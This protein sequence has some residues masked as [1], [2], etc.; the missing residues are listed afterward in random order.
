MMVTISPHYKGIHPMYGTMRDFQNF[1]RE[2]HRRRI[3]VITELVIN[4]T[5]DQHPWFQVARKPRQDQPAGTG[6]SG[7][8]N[9]QKYKDARII[10][11]D[12]ERSNWEWDPVAKAY[13]WHRFFHHQPDLN[14]DNPAV[15]REIIKVLHFWLDQGVDGLR[16]DAVPYLVEREGTLVKTCRKPTPYSRRSAGSWTY[17]MKTV[18]CWRKQTSGLP[19]CAPISATAMNAT[20]LST[21]LSCLEY[22]W[23]CD[24]KIAILSPTSCARHLQ[25]PE[26]CQWALF[27][28]NHDELTL[29]MV[30]D[31]ERDYM[32]HS[33]AADP[34][35]RHN[36]G[37]RRRL[38]PLMDNSRR[39]MELLCSLLFSFRG[40]P[41]IYYGDEIGMGDN[42]YLGDRN[43][44]R[45][46]MQWSADRNAGFSRAD[47]AQLY[48]PPIM[49]TIYG[50]Q[51]IN[52]EAQQR[53]PSSL[54]NWMKHLI[55][56]RNS[57]HVFGRG[58]TEFLNPANR[59]VLVHIR[60]H[61]EDIVL[62][63][64][65]LSRFVQPA[66]LDLSAYAGLTPVEMM[67]RIEFPRISEAPY[68]LSLG[69]H[70]FYWFQLQRIPETISLRVFSPPSE[71]PQ[72]VPLLEIAER[73]DS[74]MART[75]ATDHALEIAQPFLKRQRWFAGKSKEIGSATIE[76]RIFLITSRVLAFIDL[77]RVQYKG[78][79]EEMYALPLA[80]VPPNTRVDN[81]HL[82]ARVRTADG[83]GLLIDAMADDVIC[84]SLL[85]A[86]G[87]KLQL[88]TKKGTFVA[89]ADPMYLNE[90]AA[91]QT[92]LR[93]NRSM[94]E[95]TNTSVVF[96]ER[97]ILKLFRKLEP[98]PNPEFE[99]L[100]YLTES[101][102][103]DRTPKLAGHFEY[104]PHQGEAITVG[105]LE[106]YI[107]N[108]GNAWNHT[109]DELRRYFER[110]ERMRFDVDIPT[111]Y[112]S[113]FWSLLMHSAPQ[114]LLDAIG[115]YAEEASI[116]GRRT[117]E[118]HVAL[119]AAKEPALAPEPITPEDYAALSRNFISHAQRVFDTLQGAA[120]EKELQQK[121]RIVLE[122]RQKVLR[123]F[124][125]ISNIREEFRKIRIHGDYHL[126]Q[127]LWSRNDFF[128]LDFE[129]EP[130]RPISERRRKQLP[131][132]DV[133]GMLRSFSYAAYAGLLSPG[134]NPTQD[135]KRMEPWARLW[136]NW[137][138][139]FF[140]KE[141]LNTSGGAEVGGPQ[142]RKNLRLLLSAFMLDKALYEIQYELN[143][144]P[145][146][147]A[148]SLL[149]IQELLQNESVKDVESTTGGNPG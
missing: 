149:G 104:R 87:D 132:K 18:C 93:T 55:A 41:I 89:I 2:A 109:L 38:A 96:G 91:L 13:Y 82:L 120:V 68:F 144:R 6:M 123:L 32:Y 141:Y 139:T 12:Y 98:G 133:A 107:R 5:S 31:E 28:R 103:F 4:H 84:R 131:L 115:M 97:L 24:R 78:N 140:L 57:T 17:A 102:S 145:D 128:I 126:G 135:M 43:G 50:Y 136:N 148:I 16:L 47:F 118:L 143:H 134:T 45:T 80:L 1:V 11:T 72:P 48:S 121:V 119:A 94:G 59:K 46:P 49:D 114:I 51:A 75:I 9:D 35:M 61:D 146:W 112:T 8:D 81:E 95:Q 129:G 29:E 108:Q 130:S 63:V 127:V 101:A 88:K 67:G 124:E 77:V 39:R 19:M 125:R 22:L 83:E 65:N 70:T 110:A 25:I 117:A 92:P 76:D 62:C 137:V 36:I 21:S 23:L 147:L 100:K 34:R 138:S 122:S 99:I 66:E 90:I 33:Y 56:L 44:V 64:A 30:T 3:R 53:D 14:Y 111:V 142:Q 73:S 27:L 10:F 26:S 69:P 40:T 71:E 106:T 58:S 86:P 52:V 85:M 15:L 7:A 60:K 74:L 105:I 42:I 116:L 20:W 79:S 54:L 37:I 113:D